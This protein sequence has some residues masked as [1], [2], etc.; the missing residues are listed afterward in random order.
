GRVVR[1]RSPRPPVPARGPP[2]RLAPTAASARPAGVDRDAAPPAAAQPPRHRRPGP[3][4]GGVVPAARRPPPDDPHRRRH[5][6]RPGQPAD[7]RRRD[8]L[9]PQRADR[10]HP[11]RQG[12]GDPDPEPPFGQPGTLDPGGV[13]TRHHAQPARR[14]LAPVH[15][16]GLVQPRQKPQGPPLGA[17]PAGRRPLARAPDADPAHPARSHPGAGSGRPAA[18]LPQR[19]DPLVG[20]FSA[21][22]QRRR[23]PSARPLRQ[24]RQAARRRR[25][26]RRDRPRVR[27]PPRQRARL[28]GRVGPAPIPL[29]PRAQR[30]LRRAAPG[31][32]RLVR[33]R[34]VRPRPPDQRRP[35]GQDPHRRMDHRDPGPPDDADRDARQL[36]GP[37][38]RAIAQADRPPRLRR[39][40][41]RHPGVEDEPFWGP[42]RPDRGVRRR[43][44]DAPADPGRTGAA[45]R[46]RRRPARRAV[47]RGTG[48]SPRVRPAGRV[49]PGRPLLLVRPRP[50]RR[51]H[52][53]QL[54]PRAAN[55]RAPGRHPPG[56]GGDRHP[57][58]ARTRRA[59]LQRIPPDDAPPAGQD[60][61]RHH[62]QPGLGGGTGPRLRRRRR[63][64]RP[65]GRP[66]RRAGPQRVRVQRHR[67]PDLHPD[68]LP[69]PQLRPL[70]HQ[71]FH[72][73][74]L[75]PNRH[76]LDR[77]QR[78][79]QRVAAPRAV[80][81]PCAE[82]RQERV[83]AVGGIP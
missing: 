66:L 83:R 41:R 22:R 19:R 18:D 67:L 69:P 81:A 70:L 49:Q 2:L 3:G 82:G 30:D 13:P 71:G 74:G 76:G 31:A 35:A 46:R 51:D 48:R 55:L 78:H 29:R 80:A 62:R 38:R 50:P 24:R 27:R 53:P 52:P 36:V 65:D 33:R 11:P 34:P 1:A 42:L 15:D 23:R 44:P 68:G 6:Q 9:R 64:G 7:G 40:A 10:P 73:G 12:P 47:V 58:L 72:P 56:P 54:P 75:H 14:R 20:R 43:L 21:L 60:L 77:R 16:P 32:S 61:R 8:P 57:A 39:G 4:F 17:A 25:R 26:L 37:D 59:P 63:R 5:L 45:G 28:L 79:G